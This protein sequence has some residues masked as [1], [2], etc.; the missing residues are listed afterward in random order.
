MLARIHSA[1]TIG[2]ESRVLDVEVDASH[3][4]PRFTIVG[5]PDATV[6]EARER[7]RSALR[8]AGSRCRSEPS[9]STSPRP[10]SASAG[11]R[12]IFR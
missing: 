4:L 3:G 10:T 9:R 1:A 12:W 5:L 8:N 7:V 2:L 11:R 6:R